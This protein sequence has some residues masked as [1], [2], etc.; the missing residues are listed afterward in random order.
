MTTYGTRTGEAPGALAG[1]APVNPPSPDDM[2]VVSR[3]L[4]GHALVTA[5]GEVD[6]DTA[7]R[8]QAA[9]DDSHGQA[10]LLDLTRVSFLD[11]AGLAVL[12]TAH[13]HAE[14]RREPLRVVVDSNSPVIRP[15]EITGL[16]V[17][18]RLYHTVDEALDAANQPPRP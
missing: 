8:L 15:I 1:P 17:V 13:S 3:Q 5:T 12:V 10:C 7:P 11:S 14:A 18:L 4:D 16:D 2:D 6:V 9:L